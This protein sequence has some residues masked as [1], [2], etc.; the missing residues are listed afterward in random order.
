MADITLVQFKDFVVVALAILAFVVLLGNVVKVFK[1][2]R[3]PQES[4]TSWQADVNR[5]LNSDNKRIEDIEKAD[6]VICRGILALLSHEINGNS[7]EKLKDSQK[8]ITD[9]L[10]ER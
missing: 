6:K 4:F 8:E 7:T 5:K 10:I 3:K 2:W 1:E 9:Y